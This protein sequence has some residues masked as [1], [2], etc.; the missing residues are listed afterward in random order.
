MFGFSH[1]VWEWC[2][3]FLHWSS[4]QSYHVFIISISDITDFILILTK[5]TA[6]F[7]QSE[8]AWLAHWGTTITAQN[9][10]PYLL[11]IGPDRVFIIHG[12]WQDSPPPDYEVTL[13]VLL[14]VQKWAFLTSCSLLLHIASKY[15][16]KYAVFPDHCWE[17]LPS[18]VGLL[19]F[20]T[21]PTSGTL[22][23]YSAPGREV[24]SWLLTRQRR[25]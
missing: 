16:V 1:N 4:A 17:F 21:W 7:Q 3:W 25:I 2:V 22:N 9:N 14:A 8:L 12:G 18:L 13:F 23:I 24:C 10:V 5:L 15:A 19:D 20:I 11:L 6:T